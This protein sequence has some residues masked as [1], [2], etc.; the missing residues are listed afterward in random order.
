MLFPGQGSQ[1]VG[2]LRDLACQFI[3]PLETLTEAD[4][5]FGRAAHG[6]RL[7]DQIYP[8]PVFSDAARAAGEKK[9]SDTRIAQ[10][11]LGAMNLAAWRVLR[12]FGLH[13]DAAAGHSFGELVALCAAGRMDSATLHELARV[14]GQ[15]NEMCQQFPLPE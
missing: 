9:L 11:A 5:A 3:H 13:A 2:M 10:P 1:Y 6:E 12:H 7:S 4:R 15:V 8:I 14:R